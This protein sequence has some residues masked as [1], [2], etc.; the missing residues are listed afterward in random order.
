L[1]AHNPSLHRSANVIDSWFDLVP[2]SAGLPHIPEHSE[3][4]LGKIHLIIYNGVSHPVP[5]PDPLGSSFFFWQD[6]G[7]HIKDSL[8]T[9][10]CILYSGSEMISG[11]IKTRFGTPYSHCGMILKMPDPHPEMGGKVDVFVAEADWDDGD[12]MNPEKSVFGII[13]NK[14]E[15]RMKAYS[16]NVIWYCP[17]KE[18]LSPADDKIVCDEVLKMKEEHMKYAIKHGI[19]MIAGIGGLLHDKDKPAAVFCSEL[20][21]RV[22]KVVKRIPLEFLARNAD[23]YQ[24]AKCSCY[25][26]GQ[27]PKYVLRYQ[28]QVDPSKIKAAG[29]SEVTELFKK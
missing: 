3:F 10:D 26:H 21:A 25:D 4:R 8:K 28:V 14:F 5:Q 22:L 2:N 13:V 16:G 1:P 19:Q 6:E 20:V 9:G 29:L 17:L 12:Y 23:P 27:F 11:V 24:V 18:A 15:D 7:S